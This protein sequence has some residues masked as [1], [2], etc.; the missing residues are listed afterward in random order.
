M[1]KTSPVFDRLVP[2]IEVGSEPGCCWEWTA[3]RSRGY[4]LLRTKGRTTLAHRLVY[5]E[6]VGPIPEGLQIDHLCRNRSCV[7]P[8]HLELVSQAENLARGI[9]PPALNAHKAM[10]PKGHPYDEVN[11][12]TIPSRPG[13]RYCRACNRLNQRKRRAS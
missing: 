6:V 4:G 9:S 8:D 10:C 7:N 3:A 1:R 12:A 5:E 13:W 2:K 11:T